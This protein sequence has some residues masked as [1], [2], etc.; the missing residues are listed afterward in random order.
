MKWSVVLFL[1]GQMKV[2]P[3]MF[4]HFTN[5]LKPLANGKLCFILEVSQSQVAN[6]GSLYMVSLDSR[7]KY[8]AVLL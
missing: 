6:E 7:C 5:L 4:A 8:S 3:N 2:S 1:Q